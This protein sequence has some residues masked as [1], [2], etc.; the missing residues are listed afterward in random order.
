MPEQRRDLIDGNR[1][2]EQLYCE[3]VTEHVGA[4]GLAGAIGTAKIGEAK[5]LAKAALVAVYGV[6]RLSHA[7]PEKVG[8]IR[9]WQL[10]QSGDHD[11]RQ[12][13][14]DGS[15]GLGAAQKERALGIE[16]G[17]FQSDPIPEGQP[18]PPPSHGPGAPPPGTDKTIKGAIPPIPSC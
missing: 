18:P 5:K 17:A 13:N 16:A 2:Q 8:G 3:G 9:G 12:G 14:I 15:A 1:C 4:A 11:R 7:T 10:T 6:V